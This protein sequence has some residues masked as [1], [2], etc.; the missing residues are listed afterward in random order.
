[1][2]N[3][4]DWPIFVKVCFGVIGLALMFAGLVEIPKLNKQEAIGKNTSQE[5]TSELINITILVES[6]IDSSPIKDAVITFTF[7]GAPE[8]R[9]T[10]TN[11][12]AQI[13]IPVRQDIIITIAK[14]GFEKARF[15]VNPN[16]DPNRNKT[17]QLVP[18]KKS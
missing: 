16:N 3:I 7:K 8:V 1:M 18:Q 14:E 5:S 2:Q 15:T 4:K 12:F 17:Y 10:D 9:M 6:K 13:D 11:G